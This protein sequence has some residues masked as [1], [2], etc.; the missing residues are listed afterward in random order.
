MSTTRLLPWAVVA[1]LVAW[2]SVESVR[3]NGVALTLAIV[4]T[5]ATLAAALLTIA[6]RP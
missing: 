5:T 1:A 6:K 4:A 2:L 3:D